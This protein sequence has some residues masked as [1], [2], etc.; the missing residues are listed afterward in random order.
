M[1]Q[2]D[3]YDRHSSILA[4][5]GYDVV[6]GVAAAA[7]NSALPQYLLTFQKQSYQKVVVNQG[8]NR[9]TMS[10]DDFAK[11]SG[12]IYPTNIYDGTASS[13]TAVQ[14]CQNMGMAVAYEIQ[15]G[16]PDFLNTY[17]WFSLDG[18][19]QKVKLSLT[20]QTFTVCGFDAG[21]SCWRKLS[22]TNTP[23][24]VSNTVGVQLLQNASLQSAALHEILSSN[25][26][27]KNQAELDTLRRSITAA[28]KQVQP[29]PMSPQSLV[30]DVF[31]NPVLTIDYGKASQ[32]FIHQAEVLLT[33]ALLKV[34]N[35][36]PFVLGTLGGPLNV[37][38]SE[39]LISSYVG[40]PIALP[41]RQPSSDQQGC[42]SLNLVSM[43]PYA[44]PPPGGQ[45]WDPLPPP[46]QFTWNWLKPAD[47]QNF[48]G[49]ASL[50]RKWLSDRLLTNML[51]TISALS[52]QQN[53]EWSYEPYFFTAKTTKLVP[54]L[55]SPFIGSTVLTANSYGQSNYS[56]K[57]VWGGD[58]PTKLSITTIYEV[59][60]TTSNAQLV[61]EQLYG[62][63]I[64]Y[65]EFTIQHPGSHDQSGD[66]W[67]VRKR[68]TD[69]WS[70]EVSDNGIVTWKNINTT[71]DGSTPSYPLQG[72][73]QVDV[74]PFPPFM[75]VAE[76]PLKSMVSPDLNEI[77]K[78]GDLQQS[79]HPF[80][81]GKDFNFTNVQF[82]DNGD[83]IA[84][85]TYAG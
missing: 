61:I 16:V 1:S 35:Q 58:I 73:F 65:S 17:N 76:A 74:A 64:T 5:F 75:T 39:C 50:S 9:Q 44:L 6:I 31:T 63:H 48:H 68:V 30:A 33:D 34:G 56:A 27:A 72:N 70:A 29:T 18:A 25:N 83:L 20:F 66:C 84:T 55:R 7:V 22:Q 43:L 36:T 38:R 80:P 21:A 3:A 28:R 2:D 13:D 41:L 46:R 59:S 54:T 77:L 69:T 67:P 26:V 53:I 23:W 32:A 78:L 52:V 15:I 40:P 79:F 57:D 12:G 81:G 14:K 37:S 60:V 85:I 19:S 4:G 51:S 82:S 49:V 71:H 11:A 42:D 47:V 62:V 8:G 10:F 24:A 45:A